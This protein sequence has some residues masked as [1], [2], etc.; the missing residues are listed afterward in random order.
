MPDSKNNIEFDIDSI[1]NL[2]GGK[3]KLA[4]KHFIIGKQSPINAAIVYTAGLVNKDVIDRDILTHL[5]LHVEENLSGIAELGDYLCKK[6]ITMSNT[7]IETDINKVVEGIKRGK[8]V[9]LVEGYCNFI[10]VDTTEGVYRAVTDPETESSTR[11]PRDGFIESLETNISILRRRIKDKN[12]VIENFTVGRRSQTDLVIIY[13]DDIVDKN[14]LKDIRDRITSIDVDTVGSNSAIEQYL[15]EHT[16][17]IFP[18]VFYTERPDRV[19]ANLMEGK[20]AILLEGTPFALTVPAL[21]IQFFETVEDYNNRTLVGSFSRIIR[22]IAAVIILTFPGIYITIIKFNS[23]LIP[24]TFIQSIIESRKGLALTPFMS[25]L[26]MNLVIE[27]LREGGLRLPSKIG[28]TISVVGGIIIGDAAMKAKMVSSTTLLVLGLTTIASFLIPNYEMALSIRILNYPA[29][30]LANWLGILG[31]A[32]SIFFLIAY[33]CSL[34]SFG[35]PYFSFNKS[36]MKDTLIRAPIWKMNKS[37]NGI[38]NNNPIRQG[39]LKGKLRGKK[40]G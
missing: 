30:I 8:T 31:V 37:P 36:D 26:S 17:S 22:Y 20:I 13:I 6:Y 15:E 5:M 34:D 10:I 39:D 38:P 3:S 21:F 33:L 1:K 35:V 27:F 16:Y 2:I 23:E 7:E 4:E 28:Q 9:I 14:L 25:M 12:L 40:N 11:G 24:S 18:Q 19:Q 29:I 32:I